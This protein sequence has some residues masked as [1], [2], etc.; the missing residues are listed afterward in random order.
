MAKKKASKKAKKKSVSAKS[1]KP[2]LTPKQKRFTEEYLVDMNATKAAIRAGYSENMAEKQGSRLLSYTHVRAVVDKAVEAR[3]NRTELTQD[4]VLR[5]L[6]RIVTSRPDNY[7][8]DGADSKNPLKVKYGAPADAM[9]A[10]AG[11]NKK[12]LLTGDVAVDFKLWDKTK[13]LSLAMRHLGM[14]NDKLTLDFDE[15]TR[16]LLA[17]AADEYD[18][19][20]D[21]LARRIEAGKAKAAKG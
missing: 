5:E 19:R 3:S 14:L 9:S 7:E 4:V 11:V 12:F 16:K 21:E 17:G 6:F 20:T 2:T 15:E 13:A 8:I 10:V 1:R 18:R